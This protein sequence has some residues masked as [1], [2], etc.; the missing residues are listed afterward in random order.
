MITDRWK[1]ERRKDAAWGAYEPSVARA[2]SLR[3][4]LH[5]F[6]PGCRCASFQTWAEALDH[7]LRNGRPGPRTRY[8]S[9]A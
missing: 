6:D 7:A 8:T 5:L 4:L 9:A 1:V 2:D 3:R